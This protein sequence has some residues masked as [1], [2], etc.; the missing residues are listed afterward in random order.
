M[1]ETKYSPMIT[2]YLKVKENYPD[3]LVFYRVGD[4]YEMFFEDAQTASRE[5]DLV[6]TGKA[7]GVEEKVPMCGVP[8]HAVSSYVQRLVQR[9]Y[10]IAIVE[11]MQDPKE[12]KGIVERDVIRVITPGTVMEE[13][14]DEKASV[15]LSAVEDHS[16]GYCLSMAEASTGESVLLDIPHSAATLVQ[17]LLRNNVREVVVSHTFD[18]KLIQSL[19][20]M[21]II[22]SYCEETEIKEVYLPLCEKLKKEYQR[23]A[24]GRM[25]NYLEATQRHM[26]A[27]LQTAVIE[28][29][30]EVL[31]MDF[32]TIQ[33]LELIDPIHRETKGETLWTFLDMCKSAMGSRLLKK[34]IEKPLVNQQAIEARYDRLEYLKTNFLI[35]KRLRDHIGG[36]YDL[37]R[38]IGRCAMNSANAQDCL[39]LSKT[40]NEVPAILND[41]SSEVFPE[42]ASL[43]PLEDLRSLLDGAFVDNPPASISDGGAFRDGYNKELDEAR[44]IQRNGRQFISNMEAAERERTGIKT[45]RIGYNKVF[46]YYIDISKAAAAQVKEEWG[47]IRKQTLVNNERFISPELKEKEEMILH[48]EE[49]AIRLEK[50]LFAALLSEIR[51]RLA[52]LQRLST[53]LAELDCYATLAEVCSKYGYVR[54]VFTNDEFAIVQGRHPILNERMKKTRYVA[55]DLSMNEQESILLITG[56]NMGGKSTYMRQTALIVIM[57]QIG[58]YVPAAEVRMPVFDKIFTRI[59]ASDD[60]LS[61]QSTFM[62]EM[63][64]ANRALQEATAKSLILFDEIGRGT[65]T[66]D[67][68]ALAQAM[69]EY[70]AACVHAKTLF[71]THYHELTSLTE[72]IGVVRN[73]H[74]VVKEDKEKVTFLYKVKE[75]RADRSYGINVAKLA[76]LP[77]AVTDRAKELQKELESKK[78]VVQQSYQLIEMK[79]EDPAAKSIMDKLKSVN[80]DDLSPREAWTML[81]DLYEEATGRKE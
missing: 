1:S 39:R 46:G 48:A 62:V 53:A 23:I 56:P 51:A 80:P 60:I 59:G 50:Q 8:H 19:R 30:S 28:S 33:N 44:E 43:D 68:M 41:I 17:T 3:T 76:G 73:V 6:L 77:E 54:P 40:L 29:E 78:R 22:V 32:S 63:A 61:G 66:Y 20:E 38:L 52:K 34:W 4:F 18:E 9:G 72:S 81:T 5:L 55:N 57:A 45:L 49:N 69:I 58:C 24:Y 25:I 7:A 37:Q 79:H 21:Q 71:S 14:T 13:I 16:Y 2:Q 11:Q 27:H 67:G 65:S 31:Y 26:L 64:E 10:K 70:I 36:I 75:G 35:R 12:A 47:Y 74:V 15:F 42:F